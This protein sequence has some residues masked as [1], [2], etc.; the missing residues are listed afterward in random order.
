VSK[1]LR[2]AFRIVYE[3]ERV[4]PLVVFLLGKRLQILA[5]DLLKGF[6]ENGGGIG[7]K[8]LRRNWQDRRMM[9]AV[10]LVG[11]LRMAV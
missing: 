3:I 6:F 7:E 5:F 2:A 8:K 11:S 1:P 4:A 9:W 10:A